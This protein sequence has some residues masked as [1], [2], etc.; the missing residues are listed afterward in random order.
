[1]IISK[2][3]FEEEVRKRMDEENFR[4]ELADDVWKLKDQVRNLEFKVNMIEDSLDGKWC[5]TPYKP[6]AQRNA[7]TEQ[8]AP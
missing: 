5:A 7:A 3:R 6:G 2:R 4:R 1:M 8:E